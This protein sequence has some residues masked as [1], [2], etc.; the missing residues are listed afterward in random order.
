MAVSPGTGSPAGRFNKLFLS[1]TPL[2]FYLTLSYF[3]IRFLNAQTN[4]LVD[5]LVFETIYSLH[6]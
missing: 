5:D 4:F 3:Q 6:I 2:K 1:L